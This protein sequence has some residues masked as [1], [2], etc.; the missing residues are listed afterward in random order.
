MILLG[1]KRVLWSLF[2]FSVTVQYFII[3]H[4]LYYVAAVLITF[5]QTVGGKTNWP[6]TFI[7]WTIMVRRSGWGPIWN[8]NRTINYFVQFHHFYW[9][10]RDS[11]QDLKH[12]NRILLTDSEQ[13]EYCSL[14]YYFSQSPH[15]TTNSYRSTC[16]HSKRLVPSSY[17][18]LSLLFCK[19]KIVIIII[20]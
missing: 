10:L 3:S 15:N 2:R 17:N 8:E 4:F 1:E 7:R 14:N 16:L 19:I 18:P 5:S 11:L 6:F 20:S 12:K 13:W 9:Y